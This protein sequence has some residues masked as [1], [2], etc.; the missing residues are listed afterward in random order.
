MSNK[1]K[2]YPKQISDPIEF[3]D[4]VVKIILPDGK[5]FTFQYDPKLEALVINKVWGDGDSSISITPHVSN[6]VSIK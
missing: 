3:E 4:N 2:Y 6:Q 5:R 1:I